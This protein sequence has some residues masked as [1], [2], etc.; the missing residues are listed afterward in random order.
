MNYFYDTATYISGL[1]IGTLIEIIFYNLLLKK[2]GTFYLIFSIIQ[3]LIISTSIFITR[4]ILADNTFFMMGFLTMQT[5][6]IKK[7][8]DY[9]IIKRE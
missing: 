8:F 1:L 4:N 2:T 7:L 9:F 5:I 3:I 6:Y